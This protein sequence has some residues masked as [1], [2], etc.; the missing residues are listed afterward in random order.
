MGQSQLS[1]KS[2]VAGKLTRSTAAQEGKKAGRQEGA[3]GAG[4]AHIHSELS[5]T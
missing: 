3:C 4:R 1:P 2:S 5:A